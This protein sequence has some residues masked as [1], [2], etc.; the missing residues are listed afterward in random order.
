M[1]ILLENLKDIDKK[2]KELNSKD[3][4]KIM[5]NNLDVGIVITRT[6]DSILRGMVYNDVT[7]IY[8][9]YKIKSML[10]RTPQVN[11]KDLKYYLEL[12]IK[13]TDIWE[14]EY[15]QSLMGKG[16]RI[17]DI[18]V[19]DNGQRAVILPVKEKYR[20]SIYYRL[21]KKNGDLGVNETTLYGGKKYT[22]EN[23]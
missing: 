12:L 11:I 20:G 15:I 21:I 13:Q 8:F 10:F 23:R 16:L 6:M 22:I 5:N 17:D 4:Y 9:E 2:F 3:W 19:F 7:T 1:E 14:M 18:L